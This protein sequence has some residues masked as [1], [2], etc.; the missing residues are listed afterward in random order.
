MMY[1]QATKEN[2]D[3]VAI[4][5]LSL[6]RQ[7]FLWQHLAMI[8]FRSRPDDHPNLAHSPLLTLQ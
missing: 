5:N 4:A 1:N 3:F 6:A 7:K 2:L 8:E